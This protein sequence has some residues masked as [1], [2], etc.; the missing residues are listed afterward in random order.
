MSTRATPPSSPS[1]RSRSPSP[2]PF[3]VQHR[4]QFCGTSFVSL[5]ITTLLLLNSY[6]LFSALYLLTNSLLPS[7]LVTS[8]ILAVFA[9]VLALLYCLLHGLT[10]YRLRWALPATSRASSISNGMSQD[11]KA[12]VEDDEAQQSV[13]L[14]A[15][16]SVVGRLLLLVSLGATI[17]GITCALKDPLCKIPSNNIERVGCILHRSSVASAASTL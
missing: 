12:A 15:T 14:H 9:A 5:I 8:S 1:F 10:C 7:Q 4:H 2:T 6:I 11:D 17:T 13:A 16:A 3:S